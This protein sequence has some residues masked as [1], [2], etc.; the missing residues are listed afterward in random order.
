MKL[1]ETISHLTLSFIMTATF[2]SIFFFTYV[3]KIE[4]QIVE[5]QIDNIIKNLTLETRIFLEEKDRVVIKKII[6]NTEKPDL[7]GADKMVEENNNLLL[8]KSI[9]MFSMLFLIGMLVVCTIYFKYKIDL[10][11]VLIHTLIITGVIAL[12]YF[13]F[14]TYI[15]Q[16]YIL[17]DENYIKR[18]LL[19]ILKDKL[20]FNSGITPVIPPDIT[21]PISI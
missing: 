2:I 11:R 17:V 6:E 19:T 9:K 12:T 21:I 8:S 3:A 20:V 14:I 7:S 16:Y 18:I 1:S 10:K 5:T 4:H 13:A 15:T